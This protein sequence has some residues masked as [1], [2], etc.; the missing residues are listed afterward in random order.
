MKLF[1]LHKKKNLLEAAGPPMVEIP[2][3][4]EAPPPEMGPEMGPEEAPEEVENF[5]G[6]VETPEPPVSPEEVAGTE[7][8]GVGPAKGTINPAINVEALKSIT[9]AIEQLEGMSATFGEAA[10]AQG[11]DTPLGAKMAE[12]QSII[13]DVTNVINNNILSAGTEAP[14]EPAAEPMPEPMPEPAPAPGAA[15]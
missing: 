15:F 12:M 7:D 10:A 4:E 13:Q 2:P 11:A 8:L 6:D 5:T 3:E 9:N 1:E 14:E